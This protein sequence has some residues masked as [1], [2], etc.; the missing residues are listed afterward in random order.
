MITPEGKLYEFLKNK[1]VKELKEK[2]EYRI[3][4]L[5]W[6]TV[7]ISAFLGIRSAVAKK[8]AE[9]LLRDLERKGY[10]VERYKLPGFLLGYGFIRRGKE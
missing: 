8:V 5:S 9:K 10:K 2:G 3:E 7:I 6:D 1:V 4:A